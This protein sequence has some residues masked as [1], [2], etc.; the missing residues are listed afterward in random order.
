MITPDG[1][2]FDKEAILDYIVEKKKENKRLMKAYETYLQME[3]E[4][5]A[6]VNL[7]LYK[8]FSSSSFV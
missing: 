3:E 2:I 1:Y 6:M 4:K 7:V 5:K 8:L